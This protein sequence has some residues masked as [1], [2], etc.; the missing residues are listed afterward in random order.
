MDRLIHGDPALFLLY[1]DVERIFGIRGTLEQLAGLKDY[2]ETRRGRPRGPGSGAGIRIPENPEEIAGIAPLITVNETYFFREAIHFRLLARYLLPLYARRGRP[3]RIC[4]AATSSGCEAYSIAMLLDFYCRGRELGREAGHGGPPLSWELDAFDLN[5]AMIEA[6]RKGRYGMN[7]L[8]DDGSE[9]KPVMD[10]YLKAESRHV[11]VAELL[12]DKVRFFTHNLMEALPGTYDII[13]FRN[14]LIYFS[15]EGR[16]KVL[17]NL[18]RALAEGGSLLVGVSETASVEESRL[19]LAHRRGAFYFT[20]RSAAE[21]G[22]S[23]AG[24]AVP[25]AESG[26]PHGRIQKGPE[27]PV[28]PVPEAPVLE[29]PVPEVSVPDRVSPPQADVRPAPGLQFIAEIVRIRGREEGRPNARQVL[30]FLQTGEGTAPGSGELAAAALTL[31][32]SADLPSA[33]AVLSCLEGRGSSPVTSFLRGEFYY[34]DGGDIAAAEAKYQE[35]AAGD[36]AFWP[37]CYR[38]S[39][40]AEEGNR[41]RY[42]YRLKK[43]LGSMEKGAGRGYEIFIGGFSPDYYRHILERK[44]AE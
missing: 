14:A 36:Q 3:L 22:F 18:A 37:A 44:L 31:L 7:A 2:L 42:E 25:A 43:A 13:F 16:R 15:P 5:P 9:W 1:Q 38:I 27:P 35:A 41:A 33:A 17:D 28:Q 19:E 23:A 11:E 40:L 6:A 10:L 26:F 24:P 4:S 21:P 30:D 8:R 20:R 32:D 12:R 39:S 34:H 29:A